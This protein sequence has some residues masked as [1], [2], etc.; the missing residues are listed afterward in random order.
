MKNP[1]TKVLYNKFWFFQ[2]KRQNYLVFNKKVVYFTK[3]NTAKALLD[4]LDSIVW[5]S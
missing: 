1:L 2:K 5:I 4:N 3:S